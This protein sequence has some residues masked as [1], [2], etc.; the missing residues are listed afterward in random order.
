M[1]SRVAPELAVC[2]GFRVFAEGVEVGRVEEIWLGEWA[3][4][5]AVVVR[6]ADGRRGLLLASDVA[7]VWATERFVTVADTGRLLQLEPPHLEPDADGSRRPAASWRT[8]GDVLAPA[9][10]PRRA[11]EQPRPAGER[12]RPLWRAVGG[13]YLTVATIVALLIGLDILLSYL[14]TGSPPY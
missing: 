10:Q 9:E 2:D 8:S 13:V 14:V 5:S 12:E 6:L 11:G 1:V 3:E 7:G 4:P